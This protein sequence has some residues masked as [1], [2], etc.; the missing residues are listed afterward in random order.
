MLIKLWGEGWSAGAAAIVGAVPWHTPPNNIGM[1]D[2][3][4]LDACWAEPG[5]SPFGTQ[6]VGVV[7]TSDGE[8]GVKREDV[9]AAAPPLDTLKS[10]LALPFK[11]GHKV[12]VMDVK[13]ACLKRVAQPEDDS[14]DAQKPGTCW[15]SR[16]GCTGCSRRPGHERRIA[17]ISSRRWAWPAARQRRPVCT[18]QDIVQGRW[19][20]DATSRWQARRKASTG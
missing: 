1:Y 2:E 18:T 20:T 13:K 10:L 5:K 8:R 7:K 6:W 11:D 4:S 16:S 14:H 3:A 19:C 12:M 15:N 17:P 9:F